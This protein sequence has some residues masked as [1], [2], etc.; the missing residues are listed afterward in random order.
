MSRGAK[1][2]RSPGRPWKKDST[3]RIFF[4]AVVLASKHSRVFQGVFEERRGQKFNYR[5]GL[6]LWGR[7]Q[8]NGLSLSDVIA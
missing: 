8:V 6:W 3:A 4:S 7:A 5:A 2:A 1:N